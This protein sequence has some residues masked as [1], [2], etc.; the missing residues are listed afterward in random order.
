MITTLDGRWTASVK[1]VYAAAADAEP[2]RKP[3]TS[4]SSATARR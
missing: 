2:G 4:S 3:P 1:D